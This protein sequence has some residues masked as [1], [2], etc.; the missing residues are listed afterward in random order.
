LEIPAKSSK[1]SRQKKREKK[2]AR[3]TVSMKKIA[4]AILQQTKLEGSTNLANIS[5]RLE[6]LASKTETNASST[7]SKIKRALNVFKAIKKSNKSFAKHNMI[8]EIRDSIRN[9]QNVLMFLA[10][11]VK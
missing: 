5:E 10:A 11:K 8:Q 9:K 7:K 3:K 1:L 2:N 4:E 6:K